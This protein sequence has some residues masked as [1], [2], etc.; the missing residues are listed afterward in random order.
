MSITSNGVKLNGKRGRGFILMLIFG[1]AEGALTILLAVSLSAVFLFP[2]QANAT[3]G[4]SDILSYQGRLTDAAGSPL[5]G[6]GTNYCFQFSIYTASSGGSKLWPAGAPTTDTISVVN[7]VFNAGIGT[8]DDLSTYNFYD[9]DTIYLDI[10]VAAQVASSCVGV[11]FENL[12]P[13]QRIDAVAYAKVAR[14]VYGDL[15]KTKNDNSTVQIG[16]GTGTASPIYL[17]LDVKTGGAD[18]IGGACTQNG[19]L[20][21]NSTNTRALVCENSAIQEVGN[22]NTIVGIKEQSSGTTISSGVVNFSAV[23]N[24]TISQDGQTLKFSGPAGG[25]GNSNSDWTPYGYGAPLPATSSPGLNSLYF[26]PFYLPHDY[27]FLR[28]NAFGSFTAN[29]SNITT[30]V[31]LT[32]SAALYAR[33][34]ANPLRITSFWSGSWGIQMS[35]SGSTKVSIN[36]PVGIANSTSVSYSNYTCSVTN[37]STYLASSI[38]GPRVE[39]FPMSTTLTAGQY[40]LAWAKSSIASGTKCHIGASDYFQTISYFSTRFQPWGT[41]SSATNLGMQI[42]PGFGTYSATSGA[43]P[44]S[45]T[46]GTA[47]SWTASN[48]PIP[49]FNFSGWTTGTNLL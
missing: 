14:D 21:Y 24:L 20:W 38:S 37:C 39:F 3:A 9:N 29:I 44:A 7:G 48:A 2:D 30:T 33:D 15:L 43:F 11:S 13:R 12:F 22:A 45:I 26:A 32:E 40:W 10:G 6:T 46:L 41:N 8:A 25:G 49:F 36:N 18:T 42:V 17:A 4:V 27:Y 28:M 1:F 34:T 19:A 16:A 31:G 47:I 23:T 5:G 35:V